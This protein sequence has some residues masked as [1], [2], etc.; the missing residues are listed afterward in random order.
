[1]D[2]SL[3]KSSIKSGFFP[4]LIAPCIDFI[5]VHLY[6]ESGRLDLSLKTLDGFCV[7]KPV[8]IDETFHLKCSVEEHID[9]LALAARRSQGFVTFYTDFF[10]DHVNMDRNQNMHNTHKIF[11]RSAPEFLRRRV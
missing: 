2:W 6:P 7:G 5:S 4:K 9:F 10:P 1:V 3:P 8:V 11:R